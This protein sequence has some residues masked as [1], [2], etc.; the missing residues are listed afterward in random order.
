MLIMVK[1]TTMLNTKLLKAEL[2]LLTKKLMLYEGVTRVI[3]FMAIA[4]DE[5]AMGKTNARFV[6]SNIVRSLGGRGKQKET[7]SSKEVLFTKGENSSSETTP[8]SESDNQDPL[9]PLPKLSGAEP[10]GIN[11]QECQETQ[12]KT[13][14]V[15]DPS[16]ERNADSSTQQLLLTL[17]KKVKGLKEH[18]KPSSDNSSSVSQ[19]GSSM[20]DKGKQKARFGPC[21]H[22]W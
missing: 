14:F 4:E 11:Y 7:I 8:E 12:T 6:P 17:M 10:I 1:R 16:L 22:C 21:K 2:A 18:I 13:P 5:P 3:A 15:H 20:S 9:L 19:T